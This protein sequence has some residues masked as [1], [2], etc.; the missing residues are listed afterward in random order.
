M[1]VLVDVATAML[2]D[3]AEF[4]GIPRV[5]EQDDLLAPA[6]WNATGR[7]QAVLVMLPTIEYLLT[8]SSGP[9]SAWRIAVEEQ[10]AVFNSSQPDPTNGFAME[11]RYPVLYRKM[12]QAHQAADGRPQFSNCGTVCKANSF[13]EW[14]FQYRLGE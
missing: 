12:I 7:L 5:P 9:N 1:G 14:S 13:G 6:W 4:P 11:Y 2:Q 8:P 3:R 10:V